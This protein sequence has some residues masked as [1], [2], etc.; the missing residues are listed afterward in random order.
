[1]LTALLPFRGT[2]HRYMA[3]SVST[4]TRILLLAEGR[5]KGEGIKIFFEVSSNGGSEATG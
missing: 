1:M 4:R 2:V 5:L 3:T